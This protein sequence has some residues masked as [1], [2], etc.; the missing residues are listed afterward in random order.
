M[1]QRSA[2]GEAPWPGKGSGISLWTVPGLSC[3]PGTALTGNIAQ[4]TQGAPLDQRLGRKSPCASKTWKMCCSQQQLPLCSAP[5]AGEEGKVPLCRR[6]Q[7]ME[8][9][10]SCRSC[11]GR[12]LRVTPA[13]PSLLLHLHCARKSKLQRG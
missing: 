8:Q 1:A 9:N 3:A 7:R 10:K 2:L 12:E 11:S 6:E 4:Q 5:G 13:L